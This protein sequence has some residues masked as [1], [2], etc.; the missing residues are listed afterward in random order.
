M[1]ALAKQREFQAVLHER[2]ATLTLLQNQYEEQKRELDTLNRASQDNSYQK[3]QEEEEDEDESTSENLEQLEKELGEKRRVLNKATAMKLG[4]L[5]M[6]NTL[7]TRLGL[8][9]QSQ[10]TITPEFL[11]KLEE[12]KV[13]SGVQ[14]C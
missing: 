11:E 2:Q 5:G 7:Y 1:D 9:E 6:L 12:A 3:P 13:L 14:T 10:L 8:P 4:C